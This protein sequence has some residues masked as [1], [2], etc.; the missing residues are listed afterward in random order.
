MI[1]YGFKRRSLSVSSFGIPLVT[2]S[3]S[4]GSWYLVVV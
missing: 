1:G 2:F 3:S 4:K